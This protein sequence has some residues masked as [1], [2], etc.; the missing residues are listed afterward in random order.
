MPF[1]VQYMYRALETQILL[2]FDPPSKPDVVTI[3]QT[4]N[5]AINIPKLPALVDTLKQPVPEKEIF[6]KYILDFEAKMKSYHKM[7]LNQQL[8]GGLKGKLGAGGAGR[9]SLQ[10]IGL[11]LGQHALKSPPKALN[12]S[13]KV[14]GGRKPG[15]R[16]TSVSISEMS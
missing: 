3:T 5:N 7:Q 1:D 11:Q 10:N 14:P 13:L 16:R 4:A 6:P 15:S 12:K 2:D 8:G 9:T